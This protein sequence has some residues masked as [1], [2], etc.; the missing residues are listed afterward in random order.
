MMPHMYESD[1]E[2]PILKKWLSGTTCHSYWIGRSVLF[3]S[4][5]YIVLKHNSHASYCGRFYDNTACKAYARLYRKSD[6]ILDDL[7]YNQN[8]FSGHGEIKQWNGRISK[9]KVLD[10]CCDM[11]IVFSKEIK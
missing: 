5:D 1:I 6:F 11:G 10:D 8:L 3:E 2:N 9:S 4:D 7:G